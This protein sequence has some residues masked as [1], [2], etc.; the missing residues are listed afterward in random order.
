MRQWGKLAGWQIATLSAVGAVGSLAVANWLTH[1]GL[2]E[3]EHALNGSEALYPWTEGTIHYTVRGRGEPLLLLHDLRPGASG[4]EYRNVFSAL[5]ERYRVFAPDLLGYGLS[6]RPATRYTPQLY[7]ELIEDFLRQVVGATDQPAHVIASGHSAPFAAIAAVTQPQLFR[8]LSVIEPI[9]LGEVMS[10]RR[11]IASRV[12]R[13]LLRTP[14]LGEGAYNLLTSRLGLRLS[15]TRRLAAGAP[16]VSDDVID[17]YYAIAHLPGGRFAQAD[18]LASALDSLGNLGGEAFALVSVP[19]LL[20]WG[21]RDPAHPMSEARELRE[22][23]PGA[24]LRIFPTG[25]LPHVEAPEAFTREVFAWLRATAR[26]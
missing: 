5:A 16:R 17:Q 22:A 7:V 26:V 1:V 24:E 3:P 2:R 14:L 8:S 13:A 11:P 19:T 15:L 12:T 20:L 10:E 4:Y 18:A 21:Q 25:A 23:H 9:G 6:G